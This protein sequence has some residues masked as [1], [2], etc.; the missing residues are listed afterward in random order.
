MWLTTA[1]Q[2]ALKTNTGLAVG[3]LGTT[4]AECLFTALHGHPWN[5]PLRTQM[6]RNAGLWPA[7]NVT[8]STWA[9]HMRGVLADMDHVVEW[10]DARHERPVL[11]AWAP[12]AKRH[13]GLADLDAWTSAIPWTYAIPSG[14]RVA[15]V[16]PF[17]T[18]AAAQIPNIASLPSSTLPSLWASPPPTFFT[19]RTGCSPSLDATGP[20]AWRADQL[21]AGWRATVE[22]IVG[23]VVSGGARVA[24][25]GC[26]ALS[27]PVVVALKRHGIIAI[28][29]G[30]ALQVLFGIRGRRWTTDSV[31]GPWMQQD[32][33]CNPA[34]EETPRNAKAVEGGC[35]WYS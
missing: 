20:A 6:T 11:D 26:G 28:H 1:I 19:V 24:L 29:L 18:T 30:G 15:V 10:Y 3:K 33:W 32:T 7:T 21:A 25:V 23:T 34:D 27:L 12:L 2:D 16:T 14:T 17:A 31:V 35:Y 22:E 9:A 13:Q 5:G 8:L 4:E